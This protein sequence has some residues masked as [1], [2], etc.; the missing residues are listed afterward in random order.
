[1][2]RKIRE[3]IFDLQRAGFYEIQGGKGSH[4]KFCH[5]FY[6]GAITL[7]GKPGDDAKPYQEKQIIDA[8]EVIQNENR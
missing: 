5:I 6:Q 4:K 3:L 8:L 2:P 7:S 1:M